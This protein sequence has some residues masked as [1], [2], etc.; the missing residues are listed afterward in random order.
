[1]YPTPEELKKPTPM[2]EKKS[3]KK[4]SYVYRVPA[5]TSW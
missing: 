2:K 4:I 3:S 5:R 1:M